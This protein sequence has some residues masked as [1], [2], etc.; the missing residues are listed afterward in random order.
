VE[1]FRGNVGAT[2]RAAG[3]D[4]DEDEEM[5]VARECWCEKTGAAGRLLL[6]LLRIEWLCEG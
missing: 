3:E 6:L 4:E 1:W 2:V 5:V